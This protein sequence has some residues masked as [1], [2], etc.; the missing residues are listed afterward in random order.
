MTGTDRS[1]RCSTSTPS[2]SA[3]LADP[4]V[5]ADAAQARKLGRRYAELG[6]VVAAARELA[7][8]RDDEAAA[9]ELAAEDPSFAD[10][11]EQHAAGS[12]SWRP[13]SPSCSSRATR[14]TATTWCWRSSRGRAA[15]SRRC[16]PATWCACTCATP[17]GAA[18]RP[19]SS[20]PP[21]P[22]WAA[23]RTSRCDL[24]RRVRP[25]RACGRALK[26]EGGVHRVQR[27]PVTE[28]QGRM[29][30]SAAGVLVYPDAG[31][32]A[33]VEIDEKD[34]RIDVFRSSGHGRAERQH[35]RLRGADHA[36]AHRH[37]RVAARTSGR[38][39]R[40]ARGRWRCC[41][42][43]CRRRPRR[44]PRRRRRPTGARRCAPSTGPSGSA[45]TTSRRTGSPTTGS[46]TR[47]TTCPRCSTATSTRVLAAL[48]GGG[49]GRAAGRRRRTA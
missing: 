13:G 19:R 37:R 24:A 31:D 16:S 28:S 39:C 41:A 14:T 4:S 11:A 35:H 3:P 8:A 2:W 49:A 17:S 20:T 36:P 23:T 47:P 10:E 21:T 30:T 45:P 15:R 48:R 25:R 6:P 46:A 7:T 32:E 33:D 26:F 43:G 22:T 1:T 42:P 12:P 27:V 9:R 40:T 5:H 34:L 18:G 29:H 38:S 44:R